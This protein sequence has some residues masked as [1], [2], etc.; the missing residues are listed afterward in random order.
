MKAP[1]KVYC[2]R[3]VLGSFY[4]SPQK[5]KDVVCA[6]YINKDSLLSKL[7]ERMEQ[8]KVEAGGCSNMHA[9]GKYIAYQE[10]VN[11]INEL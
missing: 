2:W 3:G 4:C 7:T 5:Q 9:S 11:L 1:G 10:M 8:A 6:E